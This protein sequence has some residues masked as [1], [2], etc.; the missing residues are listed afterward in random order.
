MLPGETT[1]SPK[2]M[3]GKKFR[4]AS[5]LN[6]TVDASMIDDRIMYTTVK[7][8]ASHVLAIAPDVTWYIHDLTQK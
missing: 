8:P 1:S 6:Q 7:L 3:T 4:L 5:E 2:Q